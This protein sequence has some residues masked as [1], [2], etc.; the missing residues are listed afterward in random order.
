MAVRV[1]REVKRSGGLT[2]KTGV[3]IIAGQPLLLDTSTTVRL[4]DSA[5]HTASAI[6]YGIAAEST[7]QLPIAPANGLTAGQGYDYTNFARGG[8]VS[9]FMLGSEL[10]LFDDGHGLPFLT[11]G[12]ESYALNAPVFADTTT[13]KITSISTSNSAALGS[14]V[15]FDSATVPTRVRIK[16]S[17]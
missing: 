6:L 2:P 9:C 12:S 7:A 5:A 11:G 8:L 17:I 10:E 3:T 15:D 4:Y 13:G 16:F 14:I 1:I